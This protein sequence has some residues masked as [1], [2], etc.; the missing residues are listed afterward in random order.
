MD[1]F[2]Q[3]QEYLRSIVDTVREP[4]VVLDADLRV[5]SAGRSFYRHFR[6]TPAETEGQ[7]IYELGDGQWDLVE[8]RTLLGEVLL[9]NDEFNEFEVTHT[10]PRIG[11]RT[12]L[13]NARK[14]YRPGNHT[15]QILLAI[16][17]VTER[18]AEEAR[19]QGIYE[20]EHN[21]AEALQR[22]LRLEVPADS[23]PHLSIATLYEAA[24]RNEADVGGDFFDAC[25]LPRDRVALSVG[26]A[27]GKGLTAA[28]RAMQVKDVM[29]AFT[30]EYPHSPAHIVARLN[31]FVHDTRLDEEQREG[32]VCA[33]VAVMDLNSGDGAV[34]TAGVEPPLVLRANGAFEAL[35]LPCL[36]LGVESQLM[37]TAQ[38]FHLHHGD[39]LVMLT[40]GL[41]EARQDGELLGYERFVEL[42]QHHQGAPT[43]R[44]HAVA[45]MEGAKSFAGGYLHDDACIVMARRE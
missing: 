42:L 41:T 29:R 17:D 23:F 33:A 25:P 40:D 12:V 7:L 5:V 39:T 14:L 37:F 8:L 44:D 30:L 28:A 35:Y 27:S 22:P 10:F 20:R 45:V 38:P 32:F 19:L 16:E 3:T 4:L 36:P 11:T 1:L 21:I 15:H 9:R 18:R 24:R 6:V 13:L 31:D 43:L 2:V 26:D 34:V